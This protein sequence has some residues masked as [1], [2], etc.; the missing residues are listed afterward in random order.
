MKKIIIAITLAFAVI[1]AFGQESNNGNS[2]V[3][4]IRQ[5]IQKKT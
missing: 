3:K 4:R 2:E 1:E 5:T